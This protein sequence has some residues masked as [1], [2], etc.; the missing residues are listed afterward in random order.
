MLT[1]GSSKEIH[2]LTEQ[3]YHNPTPAGDLQKNVNYSDSDW[4]EGYRWD[5]L[6]Y[7]CLKQRK[8]NLKS[9]ESSN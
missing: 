5:L 9:S 7:N 2:V 6:S 4:N 8:M 3:T 1:V